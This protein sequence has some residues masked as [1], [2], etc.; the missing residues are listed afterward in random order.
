MT[1]SQTWEANNQFLFPFFTGR[2]NGVT[3]LLGVT[4]CDD[5]CWISRQ[6]W[7]GFFGESFGFLGESFGFLGDNA[8]G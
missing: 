8:I 7:F 5:V 4:L 6:F 2:R 3:M 1:F